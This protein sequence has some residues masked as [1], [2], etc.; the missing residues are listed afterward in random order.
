MRELIKLFAFIILS[1]ISIL[2][3]AQDALKHAQD[4]SLKNE[5]KNS[6]IPE[7]QLNVEQCAFNEANLRE[8]ELPG[9]KSIEERE[10][11]FD[12]YMKNSNPVRLD[13]EVKT[14]PIV[15]HIVHTGEAEGVGNNISNAQVYSAVTQLNDRFRKTPG[16]HG[17][18]DGVDT[19]I[20]FCLASID[21]DG[22]PILVDQH[23]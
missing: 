5:K 10:V 20:E 3:F 21:P 12:A 18:A 1:L 6:I 17:D 4:R 7:D 14:I 8:S 11:E 19:E 13:G 16:T 2:S 22:N 9:S 15:V 23:V